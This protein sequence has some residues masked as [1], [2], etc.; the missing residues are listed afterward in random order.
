MTHALGVKTLGRQ[1]YDNRP[2]PLLRLSL[3]AYTSAP[4][5]K[6]VTHVEQSAESAPNATFYLLASGSQSLHNFRER[7]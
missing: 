4:M 5:L 1:L 7:D 2:L 6:S 3:M